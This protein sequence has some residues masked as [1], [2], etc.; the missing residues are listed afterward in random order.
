[1]TIP[2]W[3]LISWN[4]VRST[5]PEFWCAL[6]GMRPCLD[7][8]APVGRPGRERNSPGRPLRHGQALW[9]GEHGEGL[10]GL[11]WDW[12][13]VRPDVLALSDPMAVLSNIDLVDDGGRPLDEG[14]RLVH[15]SSAV[16]ELPWQA[17]VQVTWG[18]DAEVRRA[19]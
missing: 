15:L 19:A 18:G 12:A 11:A 14:L 8:E 5:L 1:M 9:I 16:H 4:P 6:K 13:E 2:A 7:G 17:H 10:F 3:Q